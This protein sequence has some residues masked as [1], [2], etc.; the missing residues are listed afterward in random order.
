[1]PLGFKLY[2]ALSCFVLLAAIVRKLSINKYMES[3]SELDASRKANML[4][5]HSR[6][7]S[8]YKFL[9]WLSPM[10]VIMLYIFYHYVVK[11]GFYL[12]IAIAI[13]Y[14]LVFEDYVFRKR[15]LRKLEQM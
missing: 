10:F 4:R 6:V 7:L 3:V 5:A 9:F 1:M 11:H 14:L 13:M 2:L 15:I 12:S 8:C